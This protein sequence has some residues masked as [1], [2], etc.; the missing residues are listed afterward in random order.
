MKAKLFLRMS[1]GG[2]RSE[3]PRP[4][5]GVGKGQAQGEAEKL[6]AKCKELEGRLEEMEKAFEAKREESDQKKEELEEKVAVLQSGLQEVERKQAEMEKALQD[7]IAHVLEEVRHKLEDV[8]KARAEGVAQLQLKMEEKRRVIARL[9]EE[10]NATL[11]NL[12]K[13]LASHS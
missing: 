9:H 10:A 3:F 13:A 7:E 1:L 11:S 4:L 6:R 8:E 12:S 2:G 5:F